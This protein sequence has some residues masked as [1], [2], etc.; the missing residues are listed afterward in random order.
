M[1]T[2]LLKYA[3]EVERTGSIS[4]AAENLYMNQP[5]LSKAIRDLEENM[6]IT[7]FKRASKGITP[8]PKG[9]VF[10]QYAKNVLQQIENM[11]SLYLPTNSGV[12]QFD[13]V[14]PRASYIAYACT[15]L[16]KTLDQKKAL[17]INYHETNS[18]DA[19]KSVADYTHSLG[20]IRYQTIH[21]P[22][23]TS[24]TEENNLIARPVMA[25]EYLVLMSKSHPLANEC[26]LNYTQ[27]GEYIEITH[28]DLSLPMSFAKVPGSPQESKKEIAVYERGSQFELLCRIPSTYM[29]VS[30]IPEDM[31]TR[32]DLVQKKCDI[33]NN[34]YKDVL[35]YRA[36]YRPSPVDEAF[37]AILNQVVQSVQA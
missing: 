3:V 35:I 19:V 21:E 5:N 32:F 33:P 34:M 36:D 11:E 23:F 2:Q 26:R 10:L 16:V 6:G 8:T 28:G 13:I 14:V 7:I 4:R 22:F 15:E 9:K 29:W 24:L 18:I 30:S 17:Q 37:F 12:I 20:I 27:L 25:F 1:N 31:L